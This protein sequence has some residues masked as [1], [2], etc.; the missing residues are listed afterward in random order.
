[1]ENDWRH[2]AL[3]RLEDTDPELFFPVGNNG[4]ALAQMADAK[5]VCARCSVTEQCRGFALKHGEFG[6]WGGL[7]ENERRELK[8]RKARTRTR[9]V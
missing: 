3:C 8:A 7:S 9:T 2:R 1:M 6:V 4:P 5:L